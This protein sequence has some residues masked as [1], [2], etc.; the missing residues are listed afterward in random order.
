MPR[1]FMY[2]LEHSKMNSLVPSCL[3]TA[4]TL[5]SQ[6]WQSCE[7]IYVS[8]VHMMGMGGP[9]GK[10]LPGY[11]NL[12][13]IWGT[14]YRND[15]A[16]PQQWLRGPGGMLCHQIDQFSKG[17]QRGGHKLKYTDLKDPFVPPKAFC[18]S[19][20]LPVWRV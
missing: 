12:I 7:I 3:G 15:Q 16:R 20:S 8:C 11:T 6:G 9:G 2:Q 5:S 17:Q 14:G 1:V 18:N 19:P 10:P 13:S 4:G